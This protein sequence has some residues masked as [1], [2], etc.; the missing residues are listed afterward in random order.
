MKYLYFNGPFA[1]YAFSDASFANLEKCETQQGYVVCLGPSLK[2]QKDISRVYVN[3]I[4][5]KSRKQRRVARSTF[6]AECISLSESI[7]KEIV[8][9]SSFDSGIV[10]EI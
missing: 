10:K 2:N 4:E 6:G 5:A 9:R 3:L 1:I 8:D 7:G